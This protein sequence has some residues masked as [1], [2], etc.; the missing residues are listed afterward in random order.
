MPADKYNIDFTLPTGQNITLL[1]KDLLVTGKQI[2]T[3]LDNCYLGVFMSKNADQKTWYV[4]GSFLKSN[5]VVYD[6]TPLDTYGKDY[7]QVGVGAINSSAIIGEKQ[8]DTTSIHYFPKPEEKDATTNMDGFEDPY[9]IH[10]TKLDEE[11]HVKDQKK[12]EKAKN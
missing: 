10:D 4:G 11:K 8:Y 7:I 2:G 3:G 5:Y 1:G 9:V 12:Q 6:M